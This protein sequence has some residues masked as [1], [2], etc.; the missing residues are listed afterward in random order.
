M[1]ASEGINKLLVA[2]K[3]SVWGT[4]AGATGARLYRR[5]TSAFQLE[6]DTYNSNEIQ[7]SQQMRDMR[8]GT[9]RSSGTI[10]GELAG[11][12]YDEFIESAVR[13]DFTAGVT[14]GAVIVIA[15]AV[16]T[17][18]RSTGSFVSDGFQVGTVIS[19][20]GFTDAGNNGLFLITAMTTT[21]LT[22]SPLAGQTQTIEAEGDSVT[23]L[24]KGDVTWAPL[25][26]HTDDSYTVEE[27][28]DDSS[29]SRVFLGQQVNTLSLSV[30]PNAMATVEIGFS[31]RTHKP[32]PVRHTSPLRRQSLPAKPTPAL[33]VSCSS[34]V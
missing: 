4:P 19:V 15:S 29:I 16:G 30:Q 10:S 17:F 22:V 3:E 20:T 2:K 26:N 13:R 31:E 9:R 1:A 33:T 14:T 5:V 6:K 11:G 18:T 12:S 28:Y 27:W 23:I 7:P 25:T 34:T 32:L 21:V 24:Q 8:H